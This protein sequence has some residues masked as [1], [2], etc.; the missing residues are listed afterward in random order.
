VTDEY[1]TEQ[2]GISN[3]QVNGNGEDGR[4]K[5]KTKQCLSSSSVSLGVSVVVAV[6]K[7]T[8]AF[9]VL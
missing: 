7:K 8:C 9:A 6:T 2:Q 1:P 3:F 5:K 4:R